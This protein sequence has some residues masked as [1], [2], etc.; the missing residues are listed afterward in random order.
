[1]VDTAGFD[2][3]PPL[4][5]LRASDAG[6]EQ[7]RSETHD[8]KYLPNQE[9]F[10]NS[11]NFEPQRTGTAAAMHAGEMD[12]NHD[13]VYPIMSSS[14]LT[15]EENTILQ[16]L[17]ISPSLE[18]LK[19]LSENTNDPFAFMTMLVSFFRTNKIHLSREVSESLLDF[20]YP[21]LNDSKNADNIIIGSKAQYALQD[22]IVCLMKEYP[23]KDPFFQVFSSRILTDLL[24]LMRHSTGD[25]LVQ[26]FR[27][28][29]DIYRSQGQNISEEIFDRLEV[30]FCLTFTPTHTLFKQ[31]CKLID[32]TVIHG[33]D[34]YSLLKLLIRMKIN[35]NMKT[36]ELIDDILSNTQRCNSDVH[37]IVEFL[38]QMSVL[39]VVWSMTAVSLLKKHVHYIINDK[40]TKKWSINFIRRSFQWM[41]LCKKNGRYK[42]RRPMIARAMS[43]LA[44]DAPEVIRSEIYT[45]AS[46]LIMSGLMPE[47]SQ[48]FKSTG[49]FDQTF[50][51]EIDVMELRDDLMDQL[52][53]PVEKL[54]A[55]QIRRIEAK[56]NLCVRNPLSD[57]EAIKITDGLESSIL[58]SVKFFYAMIA[59]ILT[60]VV[61]VIFS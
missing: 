32:T 29:S 40:K 39:K 44:E 1:M 36:F 19:E 24:I 13:Q 25:F 4:S 26:N 6:E 7:A 22:L 12:V 60:I 41:Q 34:S 11:T 17:T 2:V 46:T 28:F 33:F 48:F 20:Y 54:R 56:R 30:D 5:L 50:L 21:F 3:V 45:C 23:S 49:A 9:Y 59:L 61:L 57:D 15:K 14:L 53:S 18:E 52:C 38:F 27:C 10:S 51:D 16:T 31:A 47:L 35:A 42:N 43:V 55:D 37:V 58:K 8:H